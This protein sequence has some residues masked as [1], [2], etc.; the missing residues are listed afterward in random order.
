MA[1]ASTRSI[2]LGFT[3]DHVASPVISAGANPASPAAIAAP[4]TLASGANT[5]TVPTGG[6]T[7]T[8]VTI[9]K[10]AG[11]TVSITLKGVT[12]DTGIALHKTDPDSISLDPSAS[13]FVLT[14]GAQIIG[15]TLIW[16]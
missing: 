1:S 9:V 2:N 14:A 10:P 5:I 7:V 15:V 6:T 8:A 12:G 13:T 11:N 3:G 4:I 16:S